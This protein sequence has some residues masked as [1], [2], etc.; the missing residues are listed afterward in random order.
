MEALIPNRSACCPP[1][2]QIRVDRQLPR[3]F[4]LVN[5]L[6]ARQQAC[7]LS[8]QPQHLHLNVRSARYPEVL[9]TGTAYTFPIRESPHDTAQCSAPPEGNLISKGTIRYFMSLAAPVCLFDPMHDSMPV[10]MHPQHL[11]LMCFV[12]A[13]VDTLQQS[14]CGRLDR[15]LIRHWFVAVQLFDC[16][17]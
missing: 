3:T 12:L 10:P 2:I 5:L 11:L 1:H 14:L 4:I 8:L 13:H 6:F 9:N 7:P 17:I 15:P 16:S